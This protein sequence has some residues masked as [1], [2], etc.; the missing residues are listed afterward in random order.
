[1]PNE[2][3]LIITIIV[4]FSLTLVWYRL[5]GVKGLFA[6]MAILTVLANIEVL[7]LVRAFGMEQ[8]LG[9]ILFASTFLITDIISETSDKENA[10]KAVN[11]GIAASITFVLIS[12]S[13]LLYTPSVN[14]VAF[15][16]IKAIFS[17]TPRVII[18]SLV[19][20]AICQRL[21]VWLYHKIWHITTR[22]TGSGTAR[23][24]VRNN[25][26]TL[27]SQLLNTI[28]FNVAAFAGTYDFMT[29]LSIIGAGYVIFIV[30]SL[31]DTPFLYIARRIGR[32]RYPKGSE[33]V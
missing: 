17:G 24:Y 25:A 7:I 18:A 11:I 8:T 1:M 32:R 14:D 3:I 21:D 30:T 20:Y 31:L 28:I 9:N 26:A 19:A 27:I 12:T 13:W 23:L 10:K 15:P 5:F 33:S 16:H 4:E 29:L 2:L 6:L 22:R